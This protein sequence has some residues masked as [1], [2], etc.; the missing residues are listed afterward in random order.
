MS[1]PKVPIK[2]PWTVHILTVQSVLQLTRNNPC[3]CSMC[4]SAVTAAQWPCHA[5]SRFGVVFFCQGYIW[6]A[7][8]F[9][10]KEKNKNTNSLPDCRRSFFGREGPFLHTYRT[11]PHTSGSNSIGTYR[12]TL[13]VCQR[14]DHDALSSTTWRDVTSRGERH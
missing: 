4:S 2:C 13:V 5:V 11:Q 9:M 1:C 6:S 14:R 10:S 7:H 3:S 8:I 12:T